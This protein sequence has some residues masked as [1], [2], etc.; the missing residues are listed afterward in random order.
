MILLQRYSD[1]LAIGLSLACT[2]HCLATPFLLAIL[3]SLAVLQLESE[4]F[5]LW[6]LVAVIPISLFA[7]LFGCKR[8]KRYRVLAFG[9]MGVALMVTA[10]FGDMLFAHAHERAEW[11]EKALTL[12]GAG[13]VAYGHVQ[14][15]S[16]CRQHHE[17]CACVEHSGGSA[18]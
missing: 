18:N 2:I 8:H 10:L 12:I 1:R 4:S 6:M 15:F 13:F 5:H 3:P 16:L 9:S 7:L 17:N 11:F 14:N